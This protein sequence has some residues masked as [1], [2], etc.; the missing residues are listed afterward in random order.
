MASN[1]IGTK[2]KTVFAYEAL[3]ERLG[4]KEPICSGCQQV[5][6]GVETYLAAV[7]AVQRFEHAPW[8]EQEP[9]IFPYLV[10]VCKFCGNTMFYNLINLGLNDLFDLHS[11]QEATA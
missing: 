3:V 1:Q 9:L 10:I 11:S 6:W 2:P 7:P 4:G 5:D 8:T